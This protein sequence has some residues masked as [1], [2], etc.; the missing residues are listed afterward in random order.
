MSLSRKRAPAKSKP[1][2]QPA[3]SNAQPPAA[4]VPISAVPRERDNGTSHTATPPQTPADIPEELIAARAY[5][6]WQQR[7]CPMGQTSDEDWYAARTELEQERL[8][9]ATP[10]ESDKHRGV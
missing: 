9:W 8:N 1:T 5:E 2:S 6:I 7:G 3:P 10:R 4:P